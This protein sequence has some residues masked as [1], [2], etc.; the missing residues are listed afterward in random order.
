MC[1]YSQILTLKIIFITININKTTN[2]LEFLHVKTSRKKHK[3]RKT[4]FSFSVF[5][6]SFYNMYSIFYAKYFATS[7]ASLVIDVFLK[8]ALFTS[9][10]KASAL[11]HVEYPT[12]IS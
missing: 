3:K 10:A 9:P 8:P 12:T 4:T 1:Y 5:C 2:F 7:L 11:M 6:I